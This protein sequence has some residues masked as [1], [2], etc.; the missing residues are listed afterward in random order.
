[1]FDLKCVPCPHTAMILDPKKNIGIEGCVCPAGKYM[2]GNRCIK[3]PLNT[4]RS[5]ASQSSLRCTPCRNDQYTKVTGSTKC[6]Y[7]PCKAGSYLDRNS[8]CLRC[9]KNTYSL[10]NAVSCTRCLVGEESAEGSTSRKS[11]KLKACQA[12]FYMKIGVGCKICPDNTWSRAGSSQCTNCKGDQESQPGS[13]RETDCKWPPC[14][15]GSYLD[16]DEGCKPCPVN[17]YGGGKLAARCTG[18]PNSRT[19]PSGSTRISQC[20]YTKCQLGASLHPI[21]GCK[22][23][24]KNTYGADGKICTNCPKGKE[25]PAGSKVAANCRWIPCEPG[26]FLDLA[27]GCTICPAGTYN[28]DGTANKCKYCPTDKTSDPR[29]SML[30]MCYWKPC[31]AGSYL[32]PDKGCRFCPKNTYSLDYDNECTKCAPGKISSERSVSPSDCQ[33]ISCKAGYYLDRD[34]GCK[35]CPAD[36]YAPANTEQSCIACLPS[37]MSKSGSVSAA[38]CQFKPCQ[39]GYYLLKDYG[40]KG[41]PHN[42]YSNKGADSCISCPSGKTSPPK[43]TSDSDCKWKPCEAGRYLDNELGCLLCPENSYK[44]RDDTWCTPCPKGKQSPEGSASIFDCTYIPC[45][46]GKFLDPAVGCVLC[47]ENTYSKF[48]GQCQDCPQGKEST[49]GSSSCTWTPC[50]VGYYLDDETGCEECPQNTYSM[51]N[52]KECTDCADL[53]N[54]TP[55]PEP[56][57]ESFCGRGKMLPDGGSECVDCPADTYKNWSDADCRPCPQYTS[58]PKGTK[59]SKDCI[60]NCDA[61]F[62][63]D[64][65]GCKSCPAGFYSLAKAGKCK[66]CPSSK[67]SDEGSA[68]CRWKDC[69]AGYYLNDAEGCKLCPANQYSDNGINCVECPPGKVSTKGSIS[70][71][72]CEWKECGEGKQVNEITG[73]CVNCPEGTYNDATYHLCQSCPEGMHSAEGSMS[74]SSCIWDECPI[75]KYVDSTT[76]CLSCPK[77]TYGGGREACKTCPS[78]KTSNEGSKIVSDC[79]WKVCSGG[80]YIDQDSGCKKCPAN[81]F[82]RG[83]SDCTPCKAHEQSSPGSSECILKTCKAGYYIESD[84]GCKPCP[85]NTYKP[86]K[87]RNDLAKLCTRC[88]EYF[89]SPSASTSI[90]SCKLKPCK[91]GFLQENKWTCSSCPEN[92]YGEDGRTCTPCPY[93]TVSLSLSRSREDCEPLPC[94]SGQYLSE[95]GCKLCPPNTYMHRPSDRTSCYPCPGRKKSP[96]GS[97]SFDDCKID[98]CEKGQFLDQNTGCQ[99]CPPNTYSSSRKARSCKKCPKNTESKL[100][101]KSISDCIQEECSA[102]YYSVESLGCVRCPSGTYSTDGKSCVD[103]LPGKI[104][105]EGSVECD[106]PSCTAGNYFTPTR[107]CT[108]CPA[109]T[110]SSVINE[111]P[112]KCMD[113]HPLQSSEPGSISSD[114]CLWPICST[115]MYLD[116]DYRCLPCP[117]NTYNGIEGASSCKDCPQNMHSKAGS[118]SCEWDACNPGYIRDETTQC[119]MCPEDTY[120][121]GNNLCLNCPEGTNSLEGSKSQIDCKTSECDDKTDNSLACHPGYFRHLQDGCLPCPV[122]T[123]SDTMEATSC[124]PCDAYQSSECASKSKASCVWRTYYNINKS[125]TLM[126]YLNFVK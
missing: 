24:P 52:A 3:C 125:R 103:C 92:T 110:Y 91:L 80:Y 74:L 17:T 19:S 94:N 62:Y 115:G 27:A 25:S 66:K 8:G 113:C 57:K 40:C 109:N 114:E 48:S 20:V 87:L 89:I 77:G 28:S 106:W 26:Y 53:P 83:G 112:T 120:S 97:A 23:C 121:S 61:G 39:A 104:S 117:A 96:E 1:M 98:K 50:D 11:C 82:S 73:E 81:T 43:S 69:N 124:T 41:C 54:N 6:D 58:S 105:S 65:D 55:V 34:S 100:G 85:E 108:P 116:Y 72:D 99:L 59:R 93:G 36:T 60:P 42:S 90:E 75:G 46:A 35:V 5:Q 16:Q 56:C 123:Y 95:E 4:F 33:W 119:T 64:K 70:S 14:D 12:G 67:I 79:A 84:V 7:K 29:S 44:G 18:C 22:L 88:P 45:A 68:I 118:A 63:L 49:E 101:S 76:G 78:G 111:K 13:T 30:S 21:N 122:N 31:S 32:D 10:N 51:D 9:P 37:Q 47:P 38:D 15:A 71:E 86:I 126:N 2:S 102:G 107:G